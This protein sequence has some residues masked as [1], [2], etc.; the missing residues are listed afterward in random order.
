MVIKEDIEY[1]IDRILAE[2]F[3]CSAD[4][5]CAMKKSSFL[6]NEVGFSAVDLLEFFLEIEKEFRICFKR[7]EILAVQ[8][9]DY[10]ELVEAVNK[11]LE[12]EML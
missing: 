2:K 11:S 10:I 1:R 12:G 3:E 8:F 9:D 5:I 4:K 7:E 6:S